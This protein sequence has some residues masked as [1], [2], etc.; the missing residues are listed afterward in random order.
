MT[1]FQPA[2]RKPLAT[3]K[4]MPLEDPVTNAVLFAEFTDDSLRC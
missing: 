2:S 3:P 1:T 4:P